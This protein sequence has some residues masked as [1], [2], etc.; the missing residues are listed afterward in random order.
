MTQTRPTTKALV[1]DTDSQQETHHGVRWVSLEEFELIHPKEKQ[2]RDQHQNKEKEK[3]KQT[4]SDSETQVRQLMLDFERDIAHDSDKDT[5]K[6]KDRNK[7]DEDI[8]ESDSDDNVSISQTLSS[9]KTVTSHTT[10]TLRVLLSQKRNFQTKVPWRRT[11][12]H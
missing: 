8:T 1:A 2:D 11:M 4:D 5:N 9:K 3:G 7:N 6:E 12:Y 10:K